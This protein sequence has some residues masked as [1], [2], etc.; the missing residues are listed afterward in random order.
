[1]ISYAQSVAI[2]F[3][4]SFLFSLFFPPANVVSRD[5]VYNFARRYSEA[6]EHRRFI[7]QIVINAIRYLETGGRFIVTRTIHPLSRFLSA[8]VAYGFV[9][10]SFTGE[11]DR[12]HHLH[13]PLSLSHSLSLSLSLSLC[14]L[15]LFQHFFHL[16]GSHGCFSFPSDDQS[17]HFFSFVRCPARRI[18]S[19]RNIRAARQRWKEAVGLKECGYHL[20]VMNQV[21]SLSRGIIN[22]SNQHYANQLT[23]F[24]FSRIFL[25]GSAI[26]PSDR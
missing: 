24:L 22:R 18:R 15:M 4:S 10:F 16:H 26:I 21:P 2:F 5:R 9:S 6:R 23:F 3:L 20:L 8:P 13:H 1:M 12:A 19:D 17:S 25:R 11:N 7:Y 14:T